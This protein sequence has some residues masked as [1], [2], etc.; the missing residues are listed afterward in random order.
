MNN[1]QP[2]H[3]SERQPN[4]SELAPIHVLLVDDNPGDVVLVQEFLFQSNIP[5]TYKYTTATNMEAACK[6]LREEAVDIVL[7]DLSLPDT[8]GS[9]TIARMREFCWQT[10]V[11][12]LSGLSNEELALLAVREGAQD[13]LCKNALEPK[14]LARTI[15][16]ARERH[17]L[18]HELEEAR[19][20]QMHA[21]KL[22]SLGV[23]T[24]GIAHDFNNILGAVMGYAELCQMSALPQETIQKYMGNIV[25]GCQRGSELC[26]QMLAY[27]GHAEIN[28]SVFDIN[29][30]LSDLASF[31]R[32]TVDPSVTLNQE[33]TQD[34][35]HIEADA[36]QVRQVLL[37]FLTNASE[38]LPTSGGRITISTGRAK[39]SAE[40]IDELYGDRAH[41]GDYVWAEVAD[42]GCG[43]AP[44][45]IRQI[46]DPFYT[47]KFEG[48]GL[49]LSAVLGIINNH[50]GTLEV[51]S[52]P[53]V[54]SSFR[55]Y[56]PLSD[57]NARVQPSLET[58]AT[59]PNPWPKLNSTVLI[60]D[61]EPGMREWL[62]MFF[63][64]I[65][66]RVIL[67]ESGEE[68]LRLFRRNLGEIDLVMIDITMPD[69][70]PTALY[71][72]FLRLRPNLHLAVITGHSPLEAQRRLKDLDGVAYEIIHKP[73]RVSDLE[74]MLD[75]FS[76]EANVT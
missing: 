34:I 51:Q 50:K 68:A 67:A 39:M 43:I 64:S 75:R 31:I 7:L 29:E 19:Q 35:G 59:A 16:H 55:A 23:L 70:E 4:I 38:A 14:L 58:S 33:I 72:E 71:R 32:I 49:G 6:I 41:S 40:D 27:A 48:R 60:A 11:V 9:E 76:S 21:Q 61:D 20:A 18:Q 3:D 28:R 44:D 13:Y 37:N 63:E 66:N 17:R 1:P 54:G 57:K 25:Q 2:N 30:I 12:I 74:A 45:K 47:T 46:F 69:T 52:K 24:G 65:G 10:P 73:F 36:S 26:R 42:N 8:V 22:E 62:G 5:Q 15:R 53:K 56:F